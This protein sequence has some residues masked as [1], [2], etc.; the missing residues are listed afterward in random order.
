[1]YQSLII[2]PVPLRTIRI[3]SDW[4]WWQIALVIVGVVVAGAIIRWIFSAVT[5]AAA[6]S[7]SAAR[8]KMRRKSAPPQAQAPLSAFDQT[9]IGGYPPN[10][11]QQ[12]GG[13]AQQSVQGSPADPQHYSQGQAQPHQGSPT[14]SYDTRPPGMA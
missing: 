3:P 9:V 1:M 5:N 6:A 10:A 4:E 13:V 8:N 14:D 7:A 2:T 11:E 12:S